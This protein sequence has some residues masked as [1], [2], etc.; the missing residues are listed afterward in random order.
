MFWTVNPLENG[1]PARPRSRRRAQGADRMNEW[2]AGGSERRAVRP[3][4]RQTRGGERQASLLPLPSSMT[5]P[6]PA[7]RGE[8]K[9]IPF[10]PPCPRLGEL[11]RD[12]RGSPPHPTPF[13]PPR[14]PDPPA[15]GRAGG[16]CARPARLPSARSTPPR[17]RRGPTRAL[18]QRAPTG[19]RPTGPATARARPAPSAGGREGGRQREGKTARAPSS[20]SPQAGTPPTLS[21]APGGRSEPA[22]R[23]PLLRRSPHT[24]RRALTTRHPW[25]PPGGPAA[26]DAPP[27]PHPVPQPP[28]ERVRSTPP[29]RP[30]AGAPPV[31]REAVRPTMRGRG[32]QGMAC[33]PGTPSR[34][35]PQSEGRRSAGPGGGG[36][37]RQHS[38]VPQSPS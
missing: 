29:P 28:P 25:G 1:A 11:S 12:S 22:P 17:A 33:A 3:A 38:P 15:L 34:G 27:L 8:N 35:V 14:P 19:S 13:S 9:V 18:P 23:R 20:I 30:A 10:S 16:T 37:R 5:A 7:W 26:G 31:A 2:D 6:S 36:G 32:R 24:Y 4:G 21:A